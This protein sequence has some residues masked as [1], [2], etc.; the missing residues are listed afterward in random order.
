MFN[1]DPRDRQLCVLGQQ[2]TLRVGEGAGYCIAM[3]AKLQ[4]IQY[5]ASPDRESNKDNN[6]KRPV[7]GGLSYE[8]Q[9]K[10]QRP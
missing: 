4:A 10:R 1:L 8:F 2:K 3:T 9:F 7:S 6:K 5:R